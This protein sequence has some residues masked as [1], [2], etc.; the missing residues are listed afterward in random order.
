MPAAAV[1]ETDCQAAQ[2]TAEVTLREWCLD[3]RPQPPRLQR[4]C[5]KPHV[6]AMP[7]VGLAV[8]RFADRRQRASRGHCG[9]RRLFLESQS[10]ESYPTLRA[11][12]LHPGGGEAGLCLARWPL[13]IPSPPR[14][15]ERRGGTRTRRRGWIGLAPWQ[16]RLA[17]S[18]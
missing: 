4:G 18:Y 17:T 11:E 12:A 9:S 3:L 16:S 5:T 7:P 15:I 6:G 10:T 13:S 2:A 8:Q 1:K 14:S